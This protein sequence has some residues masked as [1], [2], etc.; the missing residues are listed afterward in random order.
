MPRQ[1]TLFTKIIK[2]EIPADIVYED[3]FCLAFKDV[4]PQAPVHVLL[5]PKVVIPCLGEVDGNQRSLL[6]HLMIKVP[7]IAKKLG[8]GD[9]FRLVVNNGEGAGLT[10]LHLHLHIMGGRKFTWPPG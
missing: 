8:I 10:V 3:D 6:G 2:K 4:N 5:V 9:S 1:E 7:V